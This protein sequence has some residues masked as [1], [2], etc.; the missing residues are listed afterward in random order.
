M[1]AALVVT[2]V[3][4]AVACG[5]SNSST[6]TIVITGIVIRAETLTSGRGCGTAVS[7]VFKVGAVVFQDNDAGGAEP[8]RTFVAANVYDCFSD[9]TFLNL[10]LGPN[11]NANFGLYL[12]LFNADA[13]NAANGGSQLS[14]SDPTAA[15]AANSTWLAGN[16][17]WTATCTA[18]Q[19][20]QVQVLASCNPIALGTTGIDSQADAAVAP[21]TIQ[22]STDQFAMADGTL[23]TCGS[24]FDTVR[25]RARIDSDVISIVDIACGTPY[26]L[27]TPTPG[28]FTFDVGLMLAGAP[29]AQTTCS[30]PATPGLVS[31]ATCVPIP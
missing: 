21:A 16:P 25:V 6:A 5:T 11:G 8:A 31:S 28:N 29:V 27:S 7:Q 1:L 14:T 18:T 3:M 23:A 15:E 9:I 19:S 24:D 22:L 13:W 17:T 30:A 20:D 10:P 2:A 12:Y 4:G 26:V